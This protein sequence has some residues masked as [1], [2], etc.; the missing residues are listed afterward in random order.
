[1]PTWWTQEMPWFDIYLFNSC[2]LQINLGAN[3]IIYYLVCYNLVNNNKP[4]Q[5]MPDKK[6]FFNRENIRARWFRTINP[7]PPRPSELKIGGKLLKIRSG[8]RWCRDTITWSQFAKTKT[9]I[10]P[11]PSWTS[12]ESYLFI[13]FLFSR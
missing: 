4:F 2:H 13:N 9:T 12:W 3:R 7:Q 1:M 10:L 11:S 8:I 6:Y 5:N